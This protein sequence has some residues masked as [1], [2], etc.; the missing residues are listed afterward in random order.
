M[1]TNQTFMGSK[2]LLISNNRCTTPDP[3]FPLGL[4]CLNSAL[5][6]AGHDT[7]WA[8][9]L[10]DDEAVEATL[11]RYH[12]DIVGISV[13]NIDDVMVG[14][15][16]T[17]FN[18]LPSLSGMIRRKS[19][20]PVVIGGSGFSIFPRQLLELS[21]AD[22][23]IR[24]E[25]ETGLVALLAALN[26]DRDFSHVPGLVYRK[27][28]GIVINPPSGAPGAATL[29]ENDLPAAAVDYYVRHGGMLN[30]QTQRGCAHRCCYCTYPL[31]EGK[32]YRRR[33]AGGVAEEFLQ[34]QRLGARYVF[35]VDSVFNSSPRHVTEICEAMLRRDVKMSWG[36]FL[37]P[38]G[39]T[40][41][42]MKLMKQ[43]GLAHIEFGSDSFCDEVLAAYQKGLTFEDILQSSEMANREKIDFCH[44]LISGGPGETLETMRRGFDASLRIKNAVILSMVG[45]RIYPGTRLFDQALA[46]GQINAQTDLLTPKYY[47]A[48][49]L[50]VESVSAELQQFS[51]QSP[52]W[53]SG[54]PVPIYARLVERLRK[55]GAVGP[56][57]SYFS[58][59]QRLWP[60]GVK[61]DRTSP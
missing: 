20:C 59:L 26:S 52:G 4:A 11:T 19:N 39:L 2:V 22:Y 42:L 49:G 57:W 38:Q 8:D 25:G 60:N 36:C 9:R 7:L 34:L 6:R 32:Q 31:I 45:M 1:G 44:F 47:L 51:R 18:N 16:E 61:A 12:P 41:A 37:R 55:K 53:I 29:E 13:R 33:P 35:I 23:G 56:L 30:L 48:P 50:T 40:S 24:G 54:E 28:G 27:N 10:A 5:R 58:T 14:K 15:R 43:A 46:E 21:G 3:V 17:F